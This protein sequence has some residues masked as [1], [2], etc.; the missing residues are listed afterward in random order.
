MQVVP[1]G[2]CGRRCCQPACTDRTSTPDPPETSLDSEHLLFLSTRVQKYQ[3]ST[4]MNGKNLCAQM[5]H[6]ILHEINTQFQV[7]SKN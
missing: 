7:F 2:R 6:P 5:L 1:A 4:C 3:T